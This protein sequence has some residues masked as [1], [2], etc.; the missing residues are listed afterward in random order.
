MFGSDI[1]FVDYK[2]F[3]LLKTSDNC[4]N[5]IITDLI[6]FF[7]NTINQKCTM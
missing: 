3:C 1:N 6:V 7:G 4:D 5:K 2:I